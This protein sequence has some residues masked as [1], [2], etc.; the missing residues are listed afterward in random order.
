MSKARFDSNKIDTEVAKEYQNII[1][2]L[3]EDLYILKNSMSVHEEIQKGLRENEKNLHAEIV[4]YIQKELKLSLKYTSEE[5]LVKDQLLDNY[6]KELKNLYCAFKEAEE[7]NK[8]LQKDIESY[9]EALQSDT[10]DDLQ[11]N[12]PTFHRKNRNARAD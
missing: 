11:L 9:K 2:K 1:R 10:I 4:S 3:Q 8:N 5:I 6:E 12:F 7:L